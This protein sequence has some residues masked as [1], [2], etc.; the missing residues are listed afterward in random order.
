MFKNKKVRFA[1]LFSRVNMD[2]DF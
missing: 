1:G 2:Q